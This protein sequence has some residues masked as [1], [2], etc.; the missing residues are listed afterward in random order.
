MS[1]ADEYMRH[2]EVL[3][4]ENE[5]MAQANRRVAENNQRQSEEVIGNLG[6]LKTLR[7]NLDAQALQLLENPT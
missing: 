2:L 3:N 6:M 1:S 5:I 4:R 7:E